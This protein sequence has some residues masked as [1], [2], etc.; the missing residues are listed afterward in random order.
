PNLLPAALRATLSPAVLDQAVNVTC[1]GAKIENVLS[2]PQASLAFPQINYVQPTTQVVTLTIGGNDVAPVD[3]LH[4]GIAML[5]G[6]CLL[7]G[8]LVQVPYPFTLF[9]TLIPVGFP[10]WFDFL[11]CHRNVLVAGAVDKAMSLRT[12]LD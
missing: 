2:A 5:A 7:G 6:A 3:P 9:P 12:P 10:D 8:N 4:F 1:G 11:E